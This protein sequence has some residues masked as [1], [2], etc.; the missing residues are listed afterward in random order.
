MP[1]LRELQHGMRAALLGDGGEDVEPLIQA[2]GLAPAARLLIYRHHVTTTI[3]AALQATFP[4][5]CR[6]V[7]E[8]FF[9]YAADAYLR[10]HP[11]AGPCLFE[12]GES[13]A[14]FLGSFP[15][16][17]DLPYLPDVARLE[18]A[19][20]TAL[21]AADAEPLDLARLSAVPPDAV[22]D[23][24]F[25]L[26]P[27]LALI[28]SAWPVHRIWRANQPDATDE[29]VDL[30]DGRV[31]LEVRRRADDVVFRVLDTAAFAFRHALSQGQSLEIAAAAALDTDAGF[32]LAAE[33]RALLD[34]G[35]VV[36]VT[37]AAR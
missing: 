26:H 37:G 4:V 13:L 16:C 27:S 20:N 8:R 9:A 6:L 14:A 23:L 21:H 35:V 30:G 2:D 24:T 3:T 18:W 31:R 19:M 25:T 28:E 22:G 5:V 7:D 36:D 15:P 11:P 32:D 12:Y 34:D 1:T 17:R 33:L 29:V 10:A